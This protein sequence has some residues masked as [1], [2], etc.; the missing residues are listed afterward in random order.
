MSGG[1][2]VLA[3]LCQ[4]TKRAIKFWATNIAKQQTPTGTN[5]FNSSSHNTFNKKCHLYFCSFKPWIDS[6]AKN[7]AK[8]NSRKFTLRSQ[9][10]TRIANAHCPPYTNCKSSFVQRGACAS[11]GKETA[12]T[13]HAL[14]VSQKRYHG[15]DTQPSFTHPNGKY[16]RGCKSAKST[17][18]WLAK[19]LLSFYKT[20]PERPLALCK[21]AAWEMV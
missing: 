12:D 11:G 15:Q 6:S 17:G 10:G 7:Y 5:K 8:D 3:C 19:L 13:T 9:Q 1:I 20:E 16:L 14:K 18:T 4:T 2:S 21:P